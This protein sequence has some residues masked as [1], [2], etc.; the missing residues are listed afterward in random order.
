[1]AELKEKKID[2]DN[3]FIQSMKG[4]ITHHPVEVNFIKADHGAEEIHILTN[5]KSVGA[6][7]PMR[8]NTS[9]IVMFEIKDNSLQ[10]KE[11]AFAD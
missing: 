6:K 3:E 4:Q 11:V 10:Y 9:I 1:M 5:I 2:I 8:M 7:T